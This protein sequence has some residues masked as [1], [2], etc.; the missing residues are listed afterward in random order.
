VRGGR[1]FPGA[2]RAWRVAVLFLASL[3]VSVAG[4][5]MAGASPASAWTPRGAATIDNPTLTGP[6]SGPQA[7]TQAFAVSLPPGAACGG[8]TAT[9]GYQVVSY[10]VP[11]SVYPGLLAQI[12]FAGG[13]PNQGFG[14]FNQGA[15]GSS[16]SPGSLLAPQLAAAG[17]GQIQGDEIAG[18]FAWAP[19]AIPG[20]GLTVTGSLRAPYNTALIPTG[21][22]SQAWESGIACINPSGAITDYW[23]A[24]ITFSVSGTD[25]NGFTWTPSTPPAPFLPEAPVAAALPIGGAVI[26]I[27]GVAVV[28]RRRRLRRRFVSAGTTAS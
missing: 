8:D 1:V 21:Q 13:D 5:S 26:A 11:G 14:Y 7:S 22:S 28:E 4:V 17:T 19:D 15:P 27:A 18:P 3:G 12:R 23:N 24:E 2:G 6:L 20:D 25:P 16:T 9:D 10:M